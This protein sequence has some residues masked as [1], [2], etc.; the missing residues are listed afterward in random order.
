M[1]DNPL[2]FLLFTR[3]PVNFSSYAM[4]AEFDNKLKITLT[5]EASGQ[6][7]DCSA[8]NIIAL[9]DLQKSEC[10]LSDINYFQSVTQHSKL[11]VLNLQNNIQRAM[12]YLR[13]GVSGVISARH[14]QEQM[15]GIL[16]AIQAGQV[17]IE[18]DIAQA[19]AM[20]QIKKILTPFNE[21]G[22]REFDVFCLIAE[23][24]SL[25]YIAD[26]LEISSKTVSNCQT[27]IKKKLGL[28]TQAEI[29]QFAKKNRLI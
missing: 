17:F 13:A 6:I 3:V 14:S 23:D 12:T 16:Q 19:L 26:Q 5:T 20:R 1:L 21:L 18:P 10:I 15:T 22:S 9:D 28:S 25:H 27:L 8:F 24:Y 11:I 4:L 29:A 7:A 2:N